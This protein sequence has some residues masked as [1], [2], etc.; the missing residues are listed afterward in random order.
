M[1]C[2]DKQMSWFSSQWRAALK[3]GLAACLLLGTGLSLEAKPK[4]TKKAA[5]PTPEA[6]PSAT[7]KEEDDNTF[8]V[9][10]PIGHDAK[11][12]RI[13]VYSV[14]SKLQMIF[15]SEIALRLDRRQLQLMQLK[16]ATYDEEG[17]PE[18]SIDMEKS[19]F[20]LKT[21]ILTSKDPVTI[22]RTDFEITGN[23]LIFDT[24]KREG[25]FIGPVR[26]L[27]F[28]LNAETEKPPVNAPHE[29]T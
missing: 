15:E 24:E 26:M 1:N 19:V 28:N 13:P 23:N 5:S 7:P 27:I 4:K 2:R 20:D 18:M 25:K 16:I 29:K 17:K 10:I 9:P 3:L 22:R 8:D 12:I 11:G 21:Q 14:E 6:S